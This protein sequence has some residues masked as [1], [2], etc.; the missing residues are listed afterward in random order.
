MATAIDKAIAKLDELILAASGASGTNAAA[1]PAAAAAKA[2]APAAAAKAAAPAA[3]AAAAAPAAAAPAAA[4]SFDPAIFAQ[5]V[6]IKVARVLRAG[7]QEN[8]EKLLKLKVDL[9]AGDERQVMAGL[10]AWLRPEDL[11]GERR[12]QKRVGG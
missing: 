8:S 11:E 4:A 10:A 6:I 2:A 12:E 1:A 3:A 5:K 9:G 7:R